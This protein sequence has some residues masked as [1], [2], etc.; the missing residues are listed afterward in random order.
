MSFADEYSSKCQVL[1][2]RIRKFLPGLSD[3]RLD[4][5]IN[6][7]LGQCDGYQPTDAERLAGLTKFVNWLG[8]PCGTERRVGSK[9]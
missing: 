3:E 7:W 5:Y 6:R 8:E 4:T 1:S 9:N 2:H